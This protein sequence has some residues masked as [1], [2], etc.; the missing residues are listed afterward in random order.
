MSAA[1]DNILKD[2]TR[3]LPPLPLYIGRPLGLDSELKEATSLLEIESHASCCFMLGIHG[4]GDV[5]RKFA[6]ELYNEIRP[7]FVAASFLSNISEKTNESGGGLEDLQEKLLSEMG[8][9]VKAKIGS[10]EKGSAEIK[11]GLGN[12]RV[13]LVLDDVDSIEQLNSLAGGTDWFGLG[14]RIIITTRN[15]HKYSISEGSSSAVKEE[16]VVGLEKDFNMV[17]NLL[18]EEN[19]PGNVVS[20]VGMGGLGKTTLAQKVYNSIEARQL[21][22][23]RAWATISQRP[24][25]IQVLRN[26][27]KC[28]KPKSTYENASEEE[29]KENVRACLNGKKYLIVLDDVWDTNNPWGALRGCFPRNKNGSMILVTTRDHRVANALESK[30]PHLTVSLMNEEESWELFHNEVFYNTICPPE[31]EA[32]GR[33]IAKTC[34][35]YHWSSKPQPGLSQRG[36]N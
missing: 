3:I 25:L 14:S 8:S 34:N 29:L 24:V 23:R 5:I 7:H 22:P 9:E 4:D 21:F 27:L 13:L 32:I 15:E 35:G 20:I 6:A 36:R 33:S 12:K 18:K 28:L 16:N 26:L 30:N 19:S 11:R 2:V 1:I 31:L 10:T 17:I